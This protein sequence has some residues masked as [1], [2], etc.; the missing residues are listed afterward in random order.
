MVCSSAAKGLAP[1]SASSTVEPDV[2][3]SN[4]DKLNSSLA[5]LASPEMLDRSYFLVLALEFH[6]LLN[7][8]PIKMYT[9]RRR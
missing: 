4:Q 7:S 9:T 8:L 5:A 2:L 1:N 3:Y 6:M